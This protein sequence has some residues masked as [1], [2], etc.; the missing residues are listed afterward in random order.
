MC[1][2]NFCSMKITQE[3]REFAKENNLTNEDA[4]N[5]GLEEKAN[6]FKETSNSSI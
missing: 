2:P 5:K 3:V 6:E 1:G 4:L